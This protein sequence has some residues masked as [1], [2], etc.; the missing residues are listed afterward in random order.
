MKSC[1]YDD[2]INTILTNVTVLT[3]TIPKD[4]EDFDV[5][6]SIVTHLYRSLHYL[7]DLNG[8]LEYFRILNLINV[9][10]PVIVNNVWNV[11]NVSTVL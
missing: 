7:K 3:N 5:E 9:V 8:L 1:I 4:L 6:A 2:I 11:N 10:F